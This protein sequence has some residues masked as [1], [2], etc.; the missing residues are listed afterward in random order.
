MPRK[1]NLGCGMKPLPCAVNVDKVETS[2]ADIHHDLD[3]VPYPLPSDYFDEIHC[4]DVLE[5]LSDLVQIMEEIHR[6]GRQGCRV[7]I[8][9]PHFSCANSYTDP[10]HRH[11][12]GYHSFDYFTGDNQWGFYTEK[13]FRYAS[14][15]IIFDPTRKNTLVRRFAN[16]WPDFYERHLTWMLPAWFMSIKLVV[17]K[18][19]MAHVTSM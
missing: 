18:Q 8:V 1:L 12:L 17:A 13:Y 14:R 16:R 10:T 19:G 6:L 3:V 11:H 9:V 2:P 7:F 5:H 4:T 15:E